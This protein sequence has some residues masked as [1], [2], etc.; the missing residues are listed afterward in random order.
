M[1]VCR[2]TVHSTGVLH[3]EARKSSSLMNARARAYFGAKVGHEPTGVKRRA[4]RF[5]TIEKRAS[6]NHS[7][8]RH[9]NFSF[10]ACPVTS[11]ATP[12]RHQNAVGTLI[13]VLVK[14][15]DVQQ[16]FSNTARK[17]G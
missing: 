7:S 5:E 16:G 2:R 13:V 11:I 8:Q 1:A 9:M 14:M 6:V 10:V 17:T 3:A 15:G 4:W 12:N